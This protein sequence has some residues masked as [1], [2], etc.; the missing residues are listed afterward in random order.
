MRR[1]C[2]ITGCGKVSHGVG[3]CREH[4]ISAR[5]MGSLP[6][7][8]RVEVWRS[9]KHWAFQR[10]DDFYASYFAGV[11]YGDGAINGNRIRLAMTDL[12]VVINLSYF[13][14][15]PC[16]FVKFVCRKSNK[17]QAV[18]EVSSKFLVDDLRKFN[19]VEKRIS[20]V[21]SFPGGI[22][23]RGYVLGL[24]DSDGTISTTRP[25]GMSFFGNES[26]A[27]SLP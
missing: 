23:D 18:L 19:F 14:N 25:R 16:D 6:P 12:D 26:Y 5:K 8:R 9:L 20:R 1:I 10:P 4:Y 2:E 13:L 24:Y 11:L 17:P 15:L 22:N 7:S 27:C 21:F 3:L